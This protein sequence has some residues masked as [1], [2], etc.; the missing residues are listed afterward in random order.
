MK[1]DVWIA[2]GVMTVVSFCI[3]AAGPVA[4]GGR[5]LPRWAE[6]LIVLLPAALLSALV[7]VQTFADGKAL[8]L[9]ARA[10]GLAAALVAV[11]LRA[12]VLIVLLVAAVTAA[13]LR[14]VT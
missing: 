4:L 9:D 2:I 10:A 8:V 14:A 11:A 12:S 7:V 6:R 3:K 1:Q 13:G 5:D